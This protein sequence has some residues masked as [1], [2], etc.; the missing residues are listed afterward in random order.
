MSG[1]HYDDGYE[2]FIHEC[3]VDD[4]YSKIARLRRVTGI[5]KD[6]DDPAALVHLCA[7]LV[8][9]AEAYTMPAVTYD[10]IASFGM[11]AA[12]KHSGGEWYDAVI[13]MNTYWHVLVHLRTYHELIH[14]AM[15]LPS[16]EIPDAAEQL[17]RM[18]ESLIQLAAPI[19]TLNARDDD[20]NEDAVYEFFNTIWRKSIGEIIEQ[21][22]QML[23][24]A[25][26][27]P[28]GF[29]RLVGRFIRRCRVFMTRLGIT[30]S[31]E[32]G[33]LISY[34]PDSGYMIHSASVRITFDDPVKNRSVG[35]I[36]SWPETRRNESD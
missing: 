18:C 24:L 15:D 2:D 13:R 22:H 32:T 4:W 23:V 12:A 20:Y 14:Y 10:D 29:E 17:G 26:K 21:L 16:D 25:V 7:A 33:Q 1:Y 35:D 19:M 8:A 28:K 5:E 11:W 36:Y 3:F 31:S 30:H 6:C 27:L 9:D 34:D